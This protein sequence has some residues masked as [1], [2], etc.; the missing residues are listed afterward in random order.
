MPHIKHPP[1]SP[2]PADLLDAHEFEIPRS[3]EHAVDDFPTY[4]RQEFDRYLVYYT[5][6]L[7]PYF[8]DG[9]PYPPSGGNVTLPIIGQ[10]V[11]EAIKRLSDGLLDTIQCYYE[12]KLLQAMETFRGTL[13]GISFRSLAGTTTY[14]PGF[15][16]YRTRVRS[17]RPFTRQDLF[18]NPF[19]NR[20]RVATS[21][22]SVPGLPALYLGNSTYVC[23]EEYGRERIENLFFSRFQ[24]EQPVSF[25]KIQRLSD[26]IQEIRWQRF[27]G[28][29]HAMHELLSIS[30]YLILFPLYL[31]CSIR[32]RHRA[33]TFKPEYIIPQLLLQYVT[34]EKNVAGI[35]F[36]S[37]RVNYS[38]L[39]RVQAYNFVFPVKHVQS[40]GHCRELARM[41]SLTEPTSTEQEALLNYTDER[42]VKWQGI[43]LLVQDERTIT[44]TESEPRPYG[45]TAFGFLQF[46]LHSRPLCHLV[47]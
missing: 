16:F 45:N 22:Y 7:K 30:S 19:E 24:N 47:T 11:S 35:M 42:A 18:H 43:N 41:F 36:P 9:R 37:T 15:I 14:N 4:L 3:R 34:T 39:H 13:N 21:R 31:A 28:E 10:Q 40:R 20:G 46:A 32:T 27:P 25:I 44:L 2:G 26:F 17:D 38:G 33:D 8:E 1:P 29:H 6:R 12:G 23:W 5:T